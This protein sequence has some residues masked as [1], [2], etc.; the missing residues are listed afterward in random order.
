M[1]ISYLI[2]AIT[3]QIS[4]SDKTNFQRGIRLD[5][6]AAIPPSLIVL[7]IYSSVSADIYFVS[8]KFVGLGSKPLEVHLHAL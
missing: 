3:L 8:L 4:S 1:Q 5:F 2:Y 7:N 6:P